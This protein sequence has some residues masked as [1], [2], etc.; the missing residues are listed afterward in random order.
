MR[1]AVFV[2]VLL[3][4]ALIASGVC[5]GWG[6]DVLVYEGDIT[7]FDVDY[8]MS[9]TMYI[10][11]Q[12]CTGPDWHQWPVY[13]YISQDAGRTWVENHVWIP[14]CDL[15][16]M[17]LIVGHS[18]VSKTLHLFYYDWTRN[19]HAVYTHSIER[20]A[21]WNY[22]RVISE[23]SPAPSAFHAARSYR[24][25]AVPL[26]YSL[27]FAHCVGDKI[28]VL[29]SLDQA[30]TW[31][32]VLEIDDLP[33][34]SCGYHNL[35]FAL[36]WAPLK[37]YYLI[38]PQEPSESSGYPYE[39]HWAYSGGYEAD[40][41]SWFSGYQVRNLR[42]GSRP[43][44]FES[45]MVAG[46]FGGT[47]LWV[48]GSDCDPC[49]AMQF[50]YHAQSAHPF[51]W[52]LNVPWT[53]ESPPCSHGFT[54]D[55]YTDIKEYREHGNPYVNALVL[56]EDRL[57]YM[58]AS[59]ADP[60]YW[61][62]GERDINDN[63]T[64]G[65]SRGGARARLVYSPGVA[66]G[67]AGVVY[68]GRTDFAYSVDQGRNLYF[69]APWF[70]NVGPFERPYE[71][72]PFPGTLDSEESEHPM[73]YAPEGG[74]LGIEYDVV[75]TSVCREYVSHEIEVSWRA[76][77]ATAALAVTIEI[78]GAHGILATYETSDPDG[79]QLL[80]VDLPEGGSVTVL[81]TARDASGMISRAHSLEL[82]P[83]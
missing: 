10:A 32:E 78:E 74:S 51:E 48:A 26:D 65:F 70:I 40:R 31:E 21:M 7:C 39:M 16:N 67:G 17:E 18:G 68:A 61:E 30:R 37:L 20:P 41:L 1:F 28:H 58:W 29:R 24:S 54:T 44:C 81:V 12:A 75:S 80:E 79:S 6:T 50:G 36:G 5:Y 13:F 9:G 47:I 27:V 3:G 14:G 34:Y 66:T 76:S 45:P 56:S 72:Y 73:T 59:S 46:S 43:V 25:G 42:Y 2:C 64:N 82:P 4:T 11:F 8:D 35:H 63:P 19:L 33:S 38:Y 22:D 69:D 52:R 83:C 23:D 15:W 55:G 60:L 57:T 49:P 53:H 77:G 71:P 62:V